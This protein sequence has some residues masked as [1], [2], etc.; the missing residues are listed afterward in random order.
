MDVWNHDAEVTRIRTARASDMGAMLG[1][2]REHFADQ[3][4]RS[5]NPEKARHG[6][7]LLL[8]RTDR[9]RV[10][11]AETDHRIVAMC[12]V[13]IVV[14]T[15]E[16]GEAGLVEN[17]VIGPSFRSHGVGRQLLFGL[18]EWC[19]RRGLGRLQLAV[20]PDDAVNGELYRGLGWEN[21]RL[22]SLHRYL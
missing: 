18:E 16:G 20:Y 1:L 5:F 7:C 9:A 2:L 3:G 6:L 14:S 15:A 13:Q 11:V 22:V 8:Q 12:S 10:L 4:G 19:S 21:T 17:V